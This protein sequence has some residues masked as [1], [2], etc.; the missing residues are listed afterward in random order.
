MIVMLK[1]VGY[2]VSTI[3]VLLLGAAAWRSASEDPV[4]QLCLV[5]GMV[6]SILG[7]LLRWI[8]HLQDQREK[9]RI[10]EG[11]RLAQ[12]VQPQYGR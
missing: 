4:L 12:H 6:A 5:G 2:V 8:S 10:G 1:T 7:M 3:S 9:G 11:G